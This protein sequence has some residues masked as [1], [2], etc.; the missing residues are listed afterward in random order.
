MLTCDSFRTQDLDRRVTDLNDLY[1][2]FLMEMMV[3]KLEPDYVVVMGDLFSY[4]G[5]T[6]EEFAERA[7][8]YRWIFDSAIS[9]GNILNI[10]GNHDLGYGYEISRWHLDRFE[11][12]FGASNFDFRIPLN[13]DLDSDGVSDSAFVTIINNLVLDATKE[14]ELHDEVW[15]YVRSLTPTRLGNLY[16]TAS[17]SVF[18]RIHYYI[19]NL[20]IPF[21]SELTLLQIYT[22]STFSLLEPFIMFSHVPLYKQTGCVDKPNTQLDTFGHVI[23]QNH[24]SFTSTLHLLDRVSPDVILTGHDHHGCNYKHQNSAGRVVQEYTVRSMMGDF[25]GTGALLEIYHQDNRWTHTFKYCYFVPMR[26][27]TTSIVFFIVLITITIFYFSLSHCCC[28]H[29]QIPST[30]TQPT[31]VSKEPIKKEKHAN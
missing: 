9:R 2:K 14:K 7:S 15:T 20:N 31:Q 29:D 10:T 27:I 8:R 21:K 30:K 11:K 6:D 19:T 25:S 18:K 1:M 17:L 16:G 13:E 28:Q 26:Y 23:R 4:Q 22:F 3:N 24:L 12:E 5:T